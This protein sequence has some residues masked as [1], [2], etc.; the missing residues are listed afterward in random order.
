M[1]STLTR[2]FPHNLSFLFLKCDASS[3]KLSAYVVE[4][5]YDHLCK[6]TTDFVYGQNISD[7]HP[8]LELIL[9]LETTAY[10][11]LSGLKLGQHV[12]FSILRWENKLNCR[13]NLEVDAPYLLCFT[14]LTQFPRMSLRLFPMLILWDECVI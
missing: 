3:H 10:N 11:I 1:P 13:P 9:Y 7:E 8:A 4:Y 12:M 2:K 5:F 6:A 14:F